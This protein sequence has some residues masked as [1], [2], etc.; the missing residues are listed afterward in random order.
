TELSVA[1]AVLAGITPVVTICEML[2]DE[3]G[4]A[5][6]KDDAVSYAEEHGLV[7]V[8]GQDVLDRWESRGS[9]E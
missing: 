9:A 6:S 8:G 3:T 5:L 4:F 2:D 1:L 7:F